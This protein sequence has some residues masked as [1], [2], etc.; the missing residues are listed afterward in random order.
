MRKTKKINLNGKEVEIYELRVKDIRHIFSGSKSAEV[1][2]D[3]LGELLPMA[4]NMKA[5]DLEE[6]S[7]SEVQ[8]LWNAFMEVNAVFF[9]MAAKV[10]LGKMISDS[11]QKSL[12]DSFAA[13]SKG[14]M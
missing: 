6:L 11:I 5:T 12:T 7:I 13:S 4:T 8:D 1:N 9:D 10:G 2:F 14:A 3:Q